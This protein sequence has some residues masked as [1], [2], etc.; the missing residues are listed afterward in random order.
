VNTDLGTYDG[1]PVMEGDGGRLVYNCQ[2]ETGDG[3]LIPVPGDFLGI[4]GA[5]VT[6]ISVPDSGDGGVQRLHSRMLPE[7]EIEAGQ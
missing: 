5:Y 4:P 6:E 7:T 2:P 3:C 1:Q